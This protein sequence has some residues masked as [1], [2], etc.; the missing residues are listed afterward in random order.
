MYQ[1]SIQ[2]LNKTEAAEIAKLLLD[3]QN[4]FAKNN[5]D[6]GVFN[7][8]IK[9]EIDTG[10][11]KPVKQRLRRN[12]LHFEKEEEEQL[13]QMLKQNV[14][15]ESNSEWASSPVLVRKKDGSLRYCI[16]YRAVNKLTVKDAFPLPNIESCSD[17]LGENLY[18]STLDMPASYWQLQINEQDRH[19]T[20]FITKY[21]QFEH[22]KL[23]FGLC[24]SPATFSR[25]IQL[26]LKGLTWKECLAY[27]DDVIVL[28]KTFMTT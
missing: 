27:L 4:I 26:V 17:A 18:M 25:V 5:L 15:Q 22:V 8:N 6:I 14:I 12:P 19:K 28:G 16:D 20:A 23:A 3:Y 13:K 11:A 21:G 7:G 24:N 10:N 2:H 9:H 1:R